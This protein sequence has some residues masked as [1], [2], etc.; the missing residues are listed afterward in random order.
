MCQTSA[1]PRV[2]YVCSA[3]CPLQV[4][5]CYTAESSTCAVIV[6]L[7]LTHHHRV[8]LHMTVIIHAASTC[9]VTILTLMVPAYKLYFT[10]VIQ[11]AEHSDLCHRSGVGVA[12]CDCVHAS[13]PGKLNSSTAHD[14]GYSTLL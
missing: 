12:D 10:P 11:T 3:E 9:I 7:A 6:R 14:W 5:P 1:W 2:F 4:T 8:T 13:V